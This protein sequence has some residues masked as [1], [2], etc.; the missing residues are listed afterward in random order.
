MRAQLTDDVIERIASRSKVLA[1]PAR[2]RILDAL[3]GGELTVGELARRTRLHQANLSKH[4]QLLYGVGFVAPRKEG[5]FV[6]YALNPQEVSPLCGVICGR[7]AGGTSTRPRR[8]RALRRPL[9]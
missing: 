3:R 8:T 2:L 7:F 9:A 4:L 5:L 1:E 6:Y